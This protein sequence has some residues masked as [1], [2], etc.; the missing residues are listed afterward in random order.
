MPTANLLRHLAVRHAP[1]LIASA[2]LL[3]AFQFLICAAVSSVDVSGALEAMVRSLPPLLQE[4]VA[5]QL[6]GG[7][8]PRG[9]LAFGWSH[10]VT[11]AL[12]SAVAIVLA[13]RAVA[14]ESETGAI[15]LLLS[16]PISRGAYFAAH[17]GF[18][19]AA[20]A[21]LSASGVLGTVV[22]QSVFGIERF[23]VGPL[24]RLGLAYALLQGA[25][26][27][28]ALLL[29]AF[30][31]EGG[32]V[33]SGGFLIVLISYFGEAMGRLWNK[34]AF[35]RPW[36]LHEYFPPHDILVRGLGIGRPA[37]VL[38]SVLAV[39]LLLSW[40]RFRIRDVP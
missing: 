4:I 19:L 34:A 32:R 40:A 39:S 13:A 3:A 15:E 28:I 22:G 38:G 18:A 14:G 36:T 12:G 37:A 16:Q 30:G 33:A 20:I 7:F 35:I 11:H 31:R 6:F 8:T 17:A 27:G 23:G 9:L 29:S 1:F 24:L 21:A 10:P 5:S 25:V 26:F 2:V